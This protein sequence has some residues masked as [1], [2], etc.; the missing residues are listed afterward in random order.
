[1]N[2]AS[3]GPDAPGEDDNEVIPASIADRRLLSGPEGF[4]GDLRRSVR[5]WRE[6]LA[7]FW[8][9]RGIGRCVTI[10]GSARVGEDSPHYAAGREVAR[11]L[12]EA[13]FTVMTGGGPGLMEAANRGARDAG[14]LSIGCTIE[15]PHEQLTNPYVDLAVHFRY[16]FVRKLMLVKYSEAFVFLPGG[17][18]TL[19]EVF[20]TATLIQTGKVHGFPIV[21][22]GRSYWMHMEENVRGAM[23]DEGTIDP[24]DTRLFHVTDD[25]AEAVGHILKELTIG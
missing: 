16:F 19:D 25:P 3:G 4:G 14:V 23:V 10:F 18:G 8:R 11:L 6:V 2:D 5:I 12:G 9:L 17:F 21:G 15:L 20:E 22:L 13:G 7:G 1:M 24:G